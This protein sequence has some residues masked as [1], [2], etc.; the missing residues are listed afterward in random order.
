MFYEYNGKL[1]LREVKNIVLVSSAKGG[2]GKSTT[3][4]NI[5]AGLHSLGYKVGMLD[6]DI[7]GPS[8]YMMF[9]IEYDGGQFELDPI[10]QFAYPKVSKHGIKVSSMAGRVDGSTVLEWR[11]PMLTMVLKQLAFETEWGE[12]DYLVVDMPPG[13]GDVQ[14]SMS[15]NFKDAKVVIVTTPQEVALIDCRKGIELYRNN[16]IDILGVVENMSSFACPCCGHIEHIFGEQGGQNLAK[17]YNTEILGS[18]P[19]VTDIRK[20]ADS[21]TPITIEKP[22]H[23]ISQS[24]LDVSKKIAEVFRIHNEKKAAEE[25]ER[26]KKEELE[27]AQQNDG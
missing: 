5:A 15:E 11:G 21:G 13:T 4:S 16:K 27:N 25:A 24:Y 14:I 19:I 12:L 9:G 18:I 26:K 8:Q 17:E 3:A 22:D 1:G 23:P 6:A 10:T 20:D 2:V 7:Y